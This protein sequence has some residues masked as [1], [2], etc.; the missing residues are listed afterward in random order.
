MAQKSPHMVHVLLFSGPW[1]EL[2]VL[3]PKPKEITLNIDIQKPKLIPKIEK[4][5]QEKK[6]KPIKELLKKPEP[7]LR[8]KEMVKLEK[9]KPEVVREQPK[10]EVVEPDKEAM[11]RYQDMVKRKIQ[12]ARKYPSWAKQQEYEGI[13]DVVFRVLSNGSVDGIQIVTSSGFNI[14][15]REALATINR[16]SPFLPIPK[17][18]ARKDLKM[19][20]AIVFKLRYE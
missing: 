3:N 7:R 1:L 14:L 13:V 15:D 10:V 6:L 9:P 2:K 17:D 12:E 4:L 11:L 8:H 18:V 5:S 19:E 20:V 16:A